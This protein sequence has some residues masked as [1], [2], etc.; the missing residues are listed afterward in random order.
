MEQSGIVRKLNS[1]TA[2]PEGE[3]VSLKTD[4][5]ICALKGGSFFATW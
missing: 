3:I 5:T 4:R 1:M 2:L